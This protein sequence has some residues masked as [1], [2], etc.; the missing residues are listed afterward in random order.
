V[1]ERTIFISFS[2]NYCDVLKSNRSGRQDLIFSRSVIN[3][4]SEGN[5]ISGWVMSRL[6][7][8]P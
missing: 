6:F 1:Y 7:S 4:T 8:H 2:S 3:N 5:K